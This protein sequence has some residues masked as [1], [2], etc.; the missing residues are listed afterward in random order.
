MQRNQALLKVSQFRAALALT[1][2]RSQRTVKA[3]EGHFIEGVRQADCA[4]KCEI[5]KGALSR[6]VKRIKSVL[7][8]AAKAPKLSAL[9]ELTKISSKSTIK[10]LKAHLQKGQKQSYCSQFYRVDKGLLSRSV[11]RLNSIQLM[12]I[13]VMS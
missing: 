12:T 8:Y 3:L 2:I 11:S 9:L 4:R 1:R 13:E 5:D 7:M 10:A 6:A